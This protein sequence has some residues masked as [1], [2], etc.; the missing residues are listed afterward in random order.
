MS[1]TFS[2]VELRL[3]FWK[4]KALELEAANVKLEKKLDFAD[5]LVAR[6]EGKIESLEDALG[7]NRA[8]I[9]ERL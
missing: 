5:R 4:Q 3:E 9:K 8:S 7:A 6:L 2:Q 1:E